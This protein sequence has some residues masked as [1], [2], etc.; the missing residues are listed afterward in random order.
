MGLTPGTRLG[1]Y[2]IVSLLGSGGMGEVY[3]ARDTRLDRSVAIK[4]LPSRVAADTVA[5]ERFE[6]EARTIG[7]LNHPNICVLHDIGHDG[8]VDF[9]VMEH[10]TGESL[11]DRLKKGPLP[12]EQVLQY[13]IE[14]A[15]ALDRAHRAGIVHRDLKPGNIMLTRG[16]AAG[17]THIKLL[18][19][20]LAKLAGPVLAAGGVSQAFTG[21]QRELTG[22]GT[23]VG[24][25]Q[26]MAPEQLEG[27]EADGRADIFALGAVL[28]EMATGRKAFAGK[29]QVSVI[30]AILEHHPAPL[31]ALQPLAP[32]AFEHIV[33]TC[34]AKSP[35]DRWQTARDVARELKWIAAH[36]TAPPTS[37]APRRG[38]WRWGIAAAALSALVLAAAYIGVRLAPASEPAQ[39]MRFEIPTT[40]M[41]TALNLAVSPDGRRVAFV[42]AEP[43]TNSAFLYVR[44]IDAVE[45]Q[46][47]PGTDNAALPFWAPDSRHIGF[48][49][50]RVLKQIDIAGGP[51]QTVADI[52][53]VNFG[54]GAWNA[55]NVIIFS[56]VPGSL[57]R[58]SASGGAPV[59]LTTLDAAAGEL[60]HAS[61]AFLPDGRHFLFLAGG[62]SPAQ[63][64]I[65]VGALDAPS[66]QEVLRANSN[67]IYAPPGYLLFNRD[68]TL[69][70][71]RF[72]AD[73]LALSGEP[74]RIAEAIASNPQLGRAAVAV[75]DTGLLVYRAGSAFEPT[76]LTWFDRRG[77]RL[78]EVDKPAVYRGL[79]LSPDGKFLAVHIHQEPSG[80]DVWIIDLQR[81]TSTRFT[82]NA[83]NFAPSWTRDGQ[84]ILFTSD[85]EGPQNLYR[86]AASGAG[87]E[88]MAYGN[89]ISAFVEDI[90]KNGE[91][92]VYG[93]PG[94]TTG[95]DVF[96]IP[97]TRKGEPERLVSSPFFD[98]LSKLSPDERWLAYESDE[99]GRREIYAQP[100]PKGTAKYQIS[101]DGGRYVKWSPRG[102]EIFYLKEDGTLMAADVR[103]EGTALVVGTPKVLFNANP[104]LANHR[105]S[106]LDIP[107][108]VTAD[109]QRFIVNERLSNSVQQ[110][111]LTVVVNWPS[112]LPK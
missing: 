18:D 70:A 50:Q 49:A 101:T 61:P 81:G 111:P 67:A 4:V 75:S 14:I 62:A 64:A 40:P 85:K 45:A 82:F 74:V 98:G 112:L 42:A 92:M 59:M 31:S 106:A 35:D 93:A 39:V 46:K 10:L 76:R 60:L 37:I 68:G 22:A 71:Q 102:N 99:S 104:I 77:A 15:D 41:P 8:D 3:Q 87:G 29:S 100:Y 16:G 69:M 94:G 1:P 79:G 26:Y 12:I 23:I 19:F 96:R 72:D 51:P 63:R 65:K 57:K 110:F 33:A 38:R 13:G 56:A 17:A 32:V 52:G 53:G 54:G 9:L 78:G 88:A 90:T 25:V 107:Y 91:W 43:G 48:A 36:P 55:D 34:L 5:R 27:Q 84:S 30:A 97:L 20:G 47:L 105:G 108:D 103:T 89:G 109:G 6:R 11:A 58:V 95:L 2:Q 44:P 21:E 73:A 28:Y 86:K 24:T 7:A 66:L 80:G 83:H